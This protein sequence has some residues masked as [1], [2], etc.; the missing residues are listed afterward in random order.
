MPQGMPR[1]EFGGSVQ[2]LDWLSPGGP[3]PVRI[4]YDYN[5]SDIFHFALFSPPHSCSSQGEVCPYFQGEVCPFFQ[6]PRVTIP[7]GGSVCPS[8]GHH[9]PDP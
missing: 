6:N 7:G 5:L 2:G 4:F 9:P 1:V 3:F 8:S